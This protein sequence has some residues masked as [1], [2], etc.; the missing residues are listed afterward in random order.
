MEL[1]E[2]KNLSYEEF[3]EKLFP[4]IIKNEKKIN[5]LFLKLLYDIK[6]CP[7]CKYKIKGILIA[8]PK[9]VSMI[10]FNIDFFIH[11]YQTHGCPIYE[12]I[13][14]FVEHIFN[15]KKIIKYY[16]KAFEPLIDL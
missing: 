15:D 8:H 12:T 4:I 16:K 5:W 9:E 11:Y 7:L 1:K 3:E 13:C 2:Y 10:D 14:W 6:K